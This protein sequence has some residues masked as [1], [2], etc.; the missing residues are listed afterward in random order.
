MLRARVCR[1]EGLLVDAVVEQQEGLQVGRAGV[2]GKRGVVFF[3][4]DAALVAEP[5][6][7]SEGLD[8]VLGRGG[9]VADNN[10]V[11][12][13][14]G[15]L[16]LVDTDVVGAEA[17]DRGW[18]GAGLIL[19]EES[20]NPWVPLI[21][22]DLCRRVWG[23]HTVDRI[24]I[25]ILRGGAAGLQLFRGGRVDSHG[26]GPEEGVHMAGILAGHDDGVNVFAHKLA[27]ISN[28]VRSD[29]SGGEEKF[30]QSHD[31]DG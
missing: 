19:V 10:L 7:P 29:R 5:L 17:E 31:Y 15:D 12:L 23:K 14:D 24:I 30:E 25:R 2:R 11:V 20:G 16:G 21:L 27:N 1:L 9:R 26:V 22:D 8:A 4:G 28:G 13:R 18:E 6:D 3:L